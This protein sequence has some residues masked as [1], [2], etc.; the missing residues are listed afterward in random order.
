MTTFVKQLWGYRNTPILVGDTLRAIALRELGDARRWTELVYLNDLKYPYLV[1]T[2]AEKVG[3]PGT[4]AYGELIRVPTPK[5]AAV[6]VSDPDGVYGKDLGLDKYGF[7][8]AS[9]GDMS[10]VSGYTNLR[11][12]ISARIAT[13]PGELE[14][15]PEYGCHVRAVLGG[16]SGEVE[17]LL[18][19]YFVA[20]ALAAEPRIGGVNEVGV[21]ADGDVINVDATVRPVTE[22]TPFDLNLVIAG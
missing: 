7:L 8:T 5:G 18:A 16:K 4:L 10:A 6:A 15:H 2:K 22:N 3:T 9:D 11:Q 20:Q 13:E 19:R 12:A 1:A 21:Q 14:M 17:R